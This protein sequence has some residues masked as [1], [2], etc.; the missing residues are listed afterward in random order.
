MDQGIYLKQYES[1]CKLYTI[2]VKNLKT[3]YAELLLTCKQKLLSLVENTPQFVNIFDSI[4]VISAQNNIT[5]NILSDI[6]KH[7]LEI[8]ENCKN[9]FLESEVGGNSTISLCSY[10]NGINNFIVD[11]G[12]KL[13]VYIYA[14]LKNILRKNSFHQ[15]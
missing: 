12:G 4:N 5:E 1:L 2:D 11:N 3:D 9:E 10:I 14:L 8:D 15:D 13:Y 7:A 6:E